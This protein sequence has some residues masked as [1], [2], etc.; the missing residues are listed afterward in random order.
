MIFAHSHVTTMQ[1]DPTSIVIGPAETITA[2][3]RRATS[4]HRPT[5]T[6]VKPHWAPDKWCAVPQLEKHQRQI[7]FPPALGRPSARL[8]DSWRGRQ[9]RSLA[10]FIQRCRATVPAYGCD[11]TSTR[12]RC[13]CGW[14]PN[15]AWSWRECE[16][17]QV[18]NKW[19]K[20]CADPAAKYVQVREDRNVGDWRC[21]KAS[22]W[23]C[24]HGRVRPMSPSFILRL[25][26]TG[27][28]VLD[29]RVLVWRMT[30]P[31]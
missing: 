18:C 25:V 20:E 28:I 5:Y 9:K 12:L 8:W 10:R 17:R 23:N 1:T 29:V 27:P 2:P 30:E 16:R 15:C 19:E 31:R 14:R 11:H 7:L 13:R 4:E 26:L 6:R 21:G 24:L 3:H 22:S